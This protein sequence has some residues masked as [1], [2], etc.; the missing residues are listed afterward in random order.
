[1]RIRLL[2]S[3][4]MALVCADARG[5]A[6]ELLTVF[7]PGG[8]RGS[9]V[10][11][12][13]E[14]RNLTDLRALV[15]SHPSISARKIK[16]NLFTV[17]IADATPEG[18]YDL[19]VVTAKGI[20]NPRRFAVGSLAEIVEIESNDEPKSAQ[21]IK[22]PLVINGRLKPGT[23]RDY[24]RFEGVAG[25]WLTLHFRSESLDGSA[26]P[27]LTILGPDGAELLH[28]DGRDAEPM[29]DFAVPAT[30]SY[31]VKVEERSYQAGDNNVYRLAIFTGPRLVAAFPDLL[32]RGKSQAVTLYGHQLPNGKPAGPGFAAELQK[33]DVKITAPDVGEADGGGYLPASGAI[34]DGFRYRHSGAYGLLRFGLTS[35][36]VI[37]ETNEPHDSR[38]KPQRIPFPAMIAGRFL[39]PRE[40][41]WYRFSVKKGDQVWI[42]GAGEREGKTMDLEVAVHASY[43]TMLTTFN[44]YAPKKGEATPFPL[45]TLDPFGLWKV[46]ADG[47]YDLVIRDLFGTTR[48]GPDRTYRLHVGKPREDIRVVVPP[49]AGGIAVA[50]GGSVNV[51]IAVLRRGGHEGPIRVWAEGLPAGLTAKE[52]VIPAKQSTATWTFTAAKVPIAW[53]GPMTFVA[54]TEVDGKS[55]RFPV[56]ALATVR[57]G[58]VRRCGGLIA[59]ILAK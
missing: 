39:Q 37:V 3:T 50:P 31:L 5:Q 15:G 29:L 35:E 4:M 13:V 9:T 6:P 19:W 2:L 55:Q 27:A 36:P 17:T 38:L 23:D 26:R 40:A 44:D 56:I 34:F 33:L 46:E 53:V 41:D 20:S 30:G 18:D 51:P 7:P 32:T 28:N 45:N 59:A 22:L 11:V 21:A 1:L 14:G 42:E 52:L 12:A 24:F 8:Q 43:G 49:L 25:Q 10:E 57:T 54:E 48:W 58:S 47:A 16:D